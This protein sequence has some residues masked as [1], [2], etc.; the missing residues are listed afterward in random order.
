MI[1]FANSSESSEGKPT[2]H[3]NHHAQMNFVG[4]SPPPGRRRRL[5]TLRLRKKGREGRCRA[6]CCQAFTNGI[7]EA[8]AWVIC[9]F[10]FV[11]PN[12][13]GGCGLKCFAGRKFLRN[14]KENFRK[15]QLFRDEIAVEKFSRKEMKIRPKVR[16]ETNLNQNLLTKQVVKFIFERTFLF[17][18][19]G[20]NNWS[21][22]YATFRIIAYL[23]GNWIFAISKGT[24][25]SILFENH[26]IVV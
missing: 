16:L 12:E 8:K 3:R 14:G 20:Q 5:R 23:C 7:G 19:T 18:N 2:N 22:G 21:I 17:S 26:D 1:N 4:W 11:F 15:K 9:I 24:S 25:I 6:E 10:S 13:T